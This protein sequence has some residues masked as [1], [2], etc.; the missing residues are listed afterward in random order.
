M[1]LWSSWG[2]S[3]S[4]P[5]ELCK[6]LQAQPPQFQD[7]KECREVQAAPQGLG[8]CSEGHHGSW[9][10]F[11]AVTFVTSAP[12]GARLS[13]TCWVCSAWVWAAQ[14]AGGVFGVFIC[15]VYYKCVYFPASLCM[16]SDLCLALF[17]QLDHVQPRGKARTGSSALQQLLNSVHSVASLLLGGR[18]KFASWSP[19]RVFRRELQSCLKV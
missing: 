17:S 4:L 15:L 16:G 6:K 12:A 9:C 14:S 2:S 19:V 5:E 8:N 10:C 11:Q 13:C 1:F 18:R 7:G 3:S